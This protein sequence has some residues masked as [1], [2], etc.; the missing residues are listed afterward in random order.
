MFATWWIWVAAGFI[1]GA[2]EVVVP[3]FIFLGFAIG[4]VLTGALLGLNLLGSNLFVLFLVFALASLVAW[5]ALYKMFG[6]KKD[7]TKHW[8]TDINA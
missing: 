7:Q 1:I 3:G 5:F 8:D 2:I 4:A 6:L